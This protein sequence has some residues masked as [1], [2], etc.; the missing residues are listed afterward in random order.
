MC[1]L[2][3]GVM[4]DIGLDQ[5]LAAVVVLSANVFVFARQGGLPGGSDPAAFARKLL[6]AVKPRSVIFS[7]GKGRHDNPRPE[8]I[9]PVREWGCT[10]ACTQLSER[11]QAAAVDNTGYLERSE[12]R[13]V[14][15]ESVSR[16]RSRW[17]PYL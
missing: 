6:D 14:G 15:Q 3:D 11:C 12:E 7:N 17:S 10:I 5:S 8:I 13:R 16:C 9:A 4:H 2:R 1:V